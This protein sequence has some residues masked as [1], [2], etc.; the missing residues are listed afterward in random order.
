MALPFLFDQ[1]ADSLP[2]EIVITGP[3]KIAEMIRL[4]KQGEV[5]PRRGYP[6]LLMPAS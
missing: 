1:L 2:D 6:D 4:S 3:S 5:G